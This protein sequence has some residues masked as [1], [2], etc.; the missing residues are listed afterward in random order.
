MEFT[1]YFRAYEELIKSIDKAFGKISSDFPEEV[2]CKAGCSDCCHALF[3]LTLIESLYINSKFNEKYKDMEREI[4]IDRANKADR[5]IHRIK[6]QAFK[7]QKNG[8][9]D[10]EIMG[11]MSMER[12]RCPLLNDDN[13]CALYDFRPI[14]CRVYG[15]PTETSG[16]SHICGRTGFVQGQPYPTIKMDKLYEYLYKISHEMVKNMDTKFTMMG[17][18]LMPLSMTLVTV[19]NDD[20][21]GIEEKKE[22]AEE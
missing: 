21:L 11:K 3:D 4:I 19:F 18:M 13:K 16:A 9:S 7:D 6:R 14:N 17:D 20:F 1:Q 5:E 8:S 12:V 22:E 15:V 10:I 2:K